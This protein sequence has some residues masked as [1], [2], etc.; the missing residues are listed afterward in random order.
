MT[1]FSFL[2]A[3]RNVFAAPVA[4]VSSF[5]R[6]DPKLLPLISARYV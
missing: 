4:H 3:A 5:D 2:K 6:V 1:R